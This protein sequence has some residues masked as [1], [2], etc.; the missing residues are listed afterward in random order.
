MPVMLELHTLIIT[1]IIVKVAQPVLILTKKTND[2]CHF[3]MTDLN[4]F[5]NLQIFLHNI[6][7]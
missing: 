5:R 4:N 2:I 3:L 7:L 6:V 1:E